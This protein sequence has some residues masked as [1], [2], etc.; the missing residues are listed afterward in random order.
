MLM[1][2]INTLTKSNKEVIKMFICGKCSREFEHEKLLSTHEKIFH[3]DVK[4]NDVNTSVSKDN[5][6]YTMSPINNDEIIDTPTEA[7]IIKNKVKGGKKMGIKDIFKK[8]DDTNKRLKEE[9]EIKESIQ[10][11][12]KELDKDNYNYEL[13]I[14]SSSNELLNKM[15]VYFEDISKGFRKEGHTAKLIKENKTLE[16]YEQ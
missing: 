10:Q 6:S 5:P 2:I 15:S 16:G 13:K 7:T 14:I 1:F 4:N 11:Q 12:L 8:K 9:L 3:K